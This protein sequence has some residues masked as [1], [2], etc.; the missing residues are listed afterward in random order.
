MIKIFLQISFVFF[1]LGCQLKPTK[2]V[3]EVGGASEEILILVDTRTALEFSTYHVSGSI[4]LNSQDYLILSNPVKKIRTLD[5]DLEQVIERLSRRG[6]S[7]LKKIK[8][9]GEKKN[10]LE[11]KKWHWLLKELNISQIER[12]SLDEYI[13]LNRPLRPKP[14]P[15]RTD[16]WSVENKKKILDQSTLC[17][18]SFSDS[19]CRL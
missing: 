9:I 18:S 11:N 15:A 8:L 3:E 16:V 17:F 5:P 12:M 13:E 10:S 6:I 7:P 4:H 19:L 14:E 2:L 1:V